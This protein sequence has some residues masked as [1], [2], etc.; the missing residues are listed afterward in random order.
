MSGTSLD[1]VDIAYCIFK[2]TADGWEFS[3]EKADTV[4][5]TAAWL[6]KLSGAHFLSGLDLMGL[7]AEYG[8]LL[9]EMCKAFIQK[10]NVKPDFIA[11]HGHTI[12]HQPK[13]NFTYQLGN[14][15]SLHA[16]TGLPV[17]YDFRSLD[18]ARGGQ[19]APL[20]PVGDELLFNDYDICLNLGGIA[21]LSRNEKGKRIAF[22]ICFANMGLNYLALQLNKKYDHG[23]GFASSGEVNLKML[24]DLNRVYQQI[25]TTRPSLGREFFE[26]RIKP[27]LDTKKV[28]AHDKLRTFTESTAQEIVEA[29]QLTKKP[30]RV[31]CTGGG[32]F[33]S[34]LI[35]TML[36]KCEDKAVLVLPDDAIIKFKEALVFGFLG[37][38]RKRGEDNCL[39]SVTGASVNSCGGVVVGF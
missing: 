8:Q 17:I 2:Y 15:N 7:D 34:F 31:L 28:S 12:F 20:V 33:N 16:Q 19:G 1:G 10:H 14:G 22:D 37:V 23:G 9:G 21:N 4:K 13:R 35:S 32:A 25:K 6:K 30:A 39:K 29:F 5:Y 27:V 36:D 26:Q 3:I 11:S 24:S 18:V 38:L